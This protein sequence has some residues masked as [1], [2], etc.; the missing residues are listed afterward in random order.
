MGLFL[1]MSCVVGGSRAAVEGCLSL[2]VSE[3]KGALEPTSATLPEKQEARLIESPAGVTF[4]YPD[5]FTEWDEASARL[6]RELKTPVFS[7]HIHDGDLWMFVAFADGRESAKFNPIPDYWEE[8]PACEREKWLPTAE[9]IAAYVPGVS[10]QAIAPYLREWRDDDSLG[11][12]RANPND[13]FG[14]GVDWQVV[15]FM[16]QL[17]FVYPGPGEGAAYRFSVSRRR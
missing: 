9:E 5:G 17:G 8:L 12:Q 6:S 10:P 13:E 15:D 2:F 7:F 1:A 11:G 16:R 3:R 4:V 14:Y